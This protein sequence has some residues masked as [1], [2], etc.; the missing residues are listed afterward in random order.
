M[1]LPE[2]L[3]DQ[4]MLVMAQQLGDATRSALAEAF[5]DA[6][7]PL[8]EKP[9]EPTLSE[10]LEI[11]RR[12]LGMTPAEYRAHLLAEGMRGTRR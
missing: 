2:F 11:E 3:A 5:D 9:C 8:P 4:A 6:S 1:A 7:A 12:E 10:M